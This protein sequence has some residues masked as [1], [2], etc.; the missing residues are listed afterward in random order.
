MA[1]LIRFFKGLLEFFLKPKTEEVS[2]ELKETTKNRFLTTQ[3]IIIKA[4]E[5]NHIICNGKPFKIDWHKVVLWT[6]AGGLECTSE[7]Y[8]SRTKD[9]YPKMFVVHWDGCLNS[10]MMAK[11]L[12]DRGLSVPFAVDNDGTIFQLMDTRHIAWHARGVNNVSIGVEIANAV[13]L[14][15]QKW[16]I[17]HGHGPRPIV[18]GAVVNGKELKPML[19]FYPVQLEA[20]EALT[21]AVSLALNIPL[22]VPLDKDGNLVS[23]PDK[24]VKNLTFKGIIGHYHVT[25]KKIDPAGLPLDD[26]VKQIEEDQ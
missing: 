20:L 25:D 11:V 12:K 17:K 5:P 7:Q 9:R 8:R 19:G 1:L 13:K 2:L 3:E 22:E 4:E 14:K 24:R 16:Y 18:K 10:K 21:K 23:G 15:W 6:E 26:M